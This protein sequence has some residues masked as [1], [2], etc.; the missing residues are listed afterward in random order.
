MSVFSIAQSEPIN[1]PIETKREVVKAL[2]MLPIVMEERDLL[3][4]I[5][6]AQQEVI[7][8]LEER[9]RLKDEETK[10]QGQ[11]ID[12]LMEESNLYARELN[13]ANNKNSFYL[14][15]IM[16]FSSVS[17]QLGVQMIIKEKMFVSGGLQYN[18]INNNVGFSLGLGVKLF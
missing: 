6:D 12:L 15:A 10:K 3:E 5:V 11:I 17:P 13:R 9:N 7:V 16:P 18:Q 2:K 8:F 14:F 4:E 1:I